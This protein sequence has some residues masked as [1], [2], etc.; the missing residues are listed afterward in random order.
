V[1]DRNS[2]QAADEQQPSDDL[3]PTD[4]FAKL[5]GYRLT[6]WAE[7]Q[8]E[9]SLTV[10]RRHLNRSGVLHGG[11]VTSMIDAA[12]GYSGCY[13]PVAGHVR[14]AMTLSL[15]CQFV[16]AAEEGARLTARARVSGG[17]RKIF[18]VSC[19]LRD[20]EQRLVAQGEGV[21]RYR[22][23]SEDPRGLPG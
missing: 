10:E 20:Q 14:R 2:T 11:V 18:F 22:P 17:G 15:T 7:G 13:T 16:G 9:I 6:A 8:A 23:G 4:G 12:C 1:P 21:F 19:E 5:V 3:A